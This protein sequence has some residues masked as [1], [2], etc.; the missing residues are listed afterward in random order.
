[1]NT[2][3]GR[4]GHVG[5]GPP[6]ISGHSFGNGGQIDLGCSGSLNKE[7]L[8]LR[9]GRSG[10]G[11]Q[12]ASDPIIFLSQEN[13][14]SNKKRIPVHLGDIPKTT[15]VALGLKGT[16]AAHAPTGLTGCGPVPRETRQLPSLCEDHGMRN[17]KDK[18]GVST[19]AT[20][21]SHP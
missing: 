17:E 13:S 12:T 1:M 11:A 4:R 2:R 6:E 14:F 21:K 5:H 15:G 3:T 10:K 9:F 7:S 18:Q 19:K 8:N 16:Q 20:S